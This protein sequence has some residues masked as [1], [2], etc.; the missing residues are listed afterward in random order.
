MTGVSE[1][2]RRQAAMV[3]RVKEGGNIIIKR[4][5]GTEDGKTC[6]WISMENMLKVK[7]C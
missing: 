6:A 7:P 4:G 1:E 2:K 3:K 5:V